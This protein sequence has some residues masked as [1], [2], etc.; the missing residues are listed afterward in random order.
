M[1][2]VLILSQPRYFLSPKLFFFFSS[3]NTTGVSDVQINI[4]SCGMFQ[5]HKLARKEEIRLR[6]F[7]NDDI[8]D[9]SFYVS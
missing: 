5:S 4:C 3:I 7:D 9:D 1:D 2:K 8:S 6:F